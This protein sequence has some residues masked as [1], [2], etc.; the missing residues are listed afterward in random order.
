MNDIDKIVKKGKL[1]IHYGTLI[2]FLLILY[3]FNYFDL[4]IL[5]SIIL[6]LVLSWFYYLM[7]SKLWFFENALKVKNIH[8]LIEQGLFY[9]LILRDKND[10]LQ[11]TLAD[12]ESKV[13][14]GL[15]EKEM[16]RQSKKYYLENQYM[17]NLKVKQRNT[18]FNLTKIIYFILVVTSF[19]YYY[20]VN[21]HWYFIISGAVFFMFF[22]KFKSIKGQN[23]F[24]L[25]INEIGIR[26]NQKPRMEWT[27]IS[28]EKL[29]LTNRGVELKFQFNNQEEI[30]E[31]EYYDISPFTLLNYFRYHKEMKIQEF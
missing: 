10:V 9:G 14:W 16:N 24:Q 13:K 18:T 8:E 30:I 3:A 15:I 29:K 27:K 17:D 11:F 5:I 22:L 28:N 25:D 26:V 31:T 19:G 12:H 7:V 4:H 20:L 23:K 1:L 21:P 2:F 6:S